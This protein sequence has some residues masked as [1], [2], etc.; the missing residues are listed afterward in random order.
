VSKASEQLQRA[1][2]RGRR[3]T[4]LDGQNSD[5][6]GVQ[7][8]LKHLVKRT[9]KLEKRILKLA[10]NARNAAESALHM[11]AALKIERDDAA[12]ALKTE[13]D[14]AAA[15]L[16]TEKDE[17]RDTLASEATRSTSR[18]GKFQTTA[19]AVSATAALLG[20]EYLSTHPH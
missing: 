12:K 7:V 10:I 6:D 8:I 1:Y 4:R 3:D 11:A 16:K 19:A 5:L 18:W 20:Y 2:D 14:D 15:A 9:V 17:A 13:K